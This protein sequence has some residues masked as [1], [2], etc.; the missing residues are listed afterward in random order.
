[1]YANVIISCSISFLSVFCVFFNISSQGEER[2]EMMCWQLVSIYHFSAAFLYIY[3][4]TT[5]SQLQEP[6]IRRDS[7]RIMM[8][9]ISKL[10]SF[11]KPENVSSKKSIYWLPVND[12]IVW[13]SLRRVEV[14]KWSEARIGW[15]MLFKQILRWALVFRCYYERRPKRREMK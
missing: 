1:M 3:I 13:R 5:I 4:Y 11:L 15:R 6:T 14:L 9:S 7:W 8:I 12:N 2:P 10:C